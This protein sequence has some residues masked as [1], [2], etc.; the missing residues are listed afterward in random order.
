MMPRL[1]IVLPAPPFM[2]AMIIRGY[3]GFIEKLAISVTM[4][5]IL[6]VYGI[7]RQPGQAEAL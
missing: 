5:F 3:F 2:P 4:F 1:T 7:N 6:P